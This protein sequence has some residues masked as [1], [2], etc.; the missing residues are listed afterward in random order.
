[1]KAATLRS[2]L[3]L[4]TWVGLVAGMALFIAFY[5]GAFAVFTHQLGDWAP[6]P[7]AGTRASA[8]DPVQ[9]LA[10]AQTLV[11][12]T[13]ARVP[14][15]KEAMFLVMAGDH[16][17][18]PRVFHQPP[19]ESDTYQYQL[20]ERGALVTLPQR[21]G[22]VDFLYDL[23]FTAGL[24]RTF[25]TY[26]FG[27]VCIL[28]GLALVSGVVIHAP[29]LLK[30][31]FALRIGRNVKRLWQDAHNV[32]GML[33][34]PF[35]VIFAWSGAVLALGLVLLA[36]FQYLVFDGKLMQVL[37][38]DFEL[39]PHVEPARVARPTLPVAELIARAQAA[40][41]GMEVGSIAYHD[42]GDA[43]AQ[44]ELYGEA[45]QRRLNTLAMVAMNG[46]SGQVLRAVDPRTMSPG[47]AT[48]RGLQ[49]LHFGNY[50]HSAVQWLYFVLGLAGAFLF[51]SG[52]LLWIEARRKRRQSLQPLRTQVM[53]RLTLGVCLGCV[54]GVSA[55]F[56]AGALLPATQ[57]S[58]AYY[59]VFFALLAWALL[60]A[61]SRSGAELL[62]ACAL[63]A[64]LVP[65]AGWI[66]TGEHFLAALWNAHW[67]RFGVG[68]LALLLAAVFWRMGVAV[69]RRARSG[70]GNSLWAHTPRSPHEN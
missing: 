5:A 56:I 55:L 47:T 2:F 37:A 29:V 67:T 7:A 44:I 13:L 41:P 53:A 35:H 65:V 52:N 19:G 15:A 26:L 39:V 63:L 59:A 6:A 11:D 38:S 60:R 27:V 48:L 3:A 33:S 18:V 22:F 36:P 50:G 62:Y 12:A 20:D 54:G 49:A 1:M 17:P 57:A 23:H 34:L 51:Y 69:Q 30:D 21:T 4:H 58:I 64:A 28:Y 31:L 42:V 43:N 25:G 66:G 32:I 14:D 61:P 40:V 8:T 45:D 10:Q 16:G 24:P 46:A 68:V 70:D 9:Q